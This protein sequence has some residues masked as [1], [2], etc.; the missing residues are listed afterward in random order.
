MNFICPRCHGDLQK[1]SELELSCAQDGLTFKQENGIWRF[2]LPERESHYFR[3]ISDYETVRRFE[4]RFSPDS[5]YYRALPFKDT[6]GKFSADW[7]IRASSFRAL[8]KTLTAESTV[9]DVGAGNGWLSNRLS[10]SGYSVYA[11]DLLLNPEDGLG[12]WSHYQSQFAKAQSEFVHLPFS[13]QS[14]S[15]VIFNA[16]FH[17]S[18]N[19]QETLAESL[20]VLSL[21]GT[22]I[23]MDSPVYHNAESGEQMVAERK[24]V[25]LSRH[26]FASDSLKSENYL[27][28][29][30]MDELGKMLGIA[31]R[32]IRPFYGV[33]WAIRPF[34]ARLRGGREPAEFG[35][36]VGTRL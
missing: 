22:V 31:W 33:R 14:V 25:F 17:Y 5:S 24:S 27:T 11:V 4:G 6:S 28:H 23:I 21:N 16:S 30:R 36:W 2:L 19:Y 8:Q 10:L 15:A 3:F 34:W 7:K 32:H 9:L 18:E 26:G 13:D 20:R 12:A 35:L 29:H 1:K